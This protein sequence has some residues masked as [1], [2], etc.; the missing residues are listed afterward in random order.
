MR[1]APAALRNREAIAEVLRE[2]LPETG[3]VLEVASGTG[4][5]AEF[6]AAQ[7]PALQWQPTDADEVARA[8]I[9]ARVK[10]ASLPNLQGPLALDA[11]ASDWTVGPVDAVLCINMV[12]ISPWRSALGLIS[13]AAE[14]LH[15]DGPLILYGPWFHDGV[16]TAATNA[17]FDADL[18]GRNSEWGIRQVTDFTAAAT[19]RGFKLQDLRNMPANNLMLLFLRAGDGSS[20]AL[21]AGG[22]SG[23]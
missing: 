13:G 9:A 16:P 7:F 12:H 1:S 19:D 21:A 22:P 18:R 17:A 11:S 20:S 5:H 4:E 2:W 23:E 15:A 14:R 3:L 6:F 10:A 8:S